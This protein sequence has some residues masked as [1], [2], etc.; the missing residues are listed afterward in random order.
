MKLLPKNIWLVG[1]NPNH[2]FKNVFLTI[3]YFSM[4]NMIHSF[5][6]FHPCLV[7]PIIYVL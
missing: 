3:K 6:S 2:S 7:P 5:M 4:T 1:M